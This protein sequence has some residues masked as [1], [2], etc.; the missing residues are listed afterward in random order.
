[1]GHTKIFLLLSIERKNPVVKAKRPLKFLIVSGE[2][3]GDI[4]GSQIIEELR[5]INKNIDFIGVGGKNMAEKKIRLLYSSVNWSSIGYIESLK[6]VPRLYFVY[7]NLKTVLVEEKVDLLIC[8]D[9]P[10]FNMR[11]VRYAKKLG[12]PSIYLFPPAK[13]ATD[14]DDV[15]DAA[16]NITQ[17]CASFR[18]T[19]EVYRKA[20]ANV[21]F[22]G[23]PIVDLPLPSLDKKQFIKKHNINDNSRIVGMLPGS[24]FSEIDQLLPLLLETAKIVYKNNPNSHFMIPLLSKK[25]G[26]NSEYG[27]IVDKFREKYELPLTLIWDSSH[28]VLQHVDCA[29]VTSGTAT[30]EAAFINVPMIIIYKVSNFT[31]FIA[32]LF[33]RIPKFIGLPNLVLDEKIVPELIQDDLNPQNLALEIEKLLSNDDL[34][35]EMKAKLKPIRMQLGERGVSGRLAQLIIRTI[36]Y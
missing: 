21:E 31:A 17:V 10:G 22:V 18:R 4:Y 36:G 24:R 35:K 27:K 9:F 12:I 30:L 23:H 7:L 14:P 15:K 26:G 29:V 11:L 16:L 20:G 34:C 1:M 33:N 3:S 28:E 5:K 19:Y 32:R 2:I 25:Y 6:K 13:F 8:I